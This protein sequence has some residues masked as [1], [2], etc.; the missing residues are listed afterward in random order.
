M[1]TIPQEGCERGLNRDAV[2]GFRLHLAKV[3]VY[4]KQLIILMRVWMV[5]VIVLRM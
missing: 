2:D 1:D 3:E 4:L 5:S